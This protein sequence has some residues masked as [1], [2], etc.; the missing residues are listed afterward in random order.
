MQLCRKD[1]P[2]YTLIPALQKKSM[3]TDALDKGRSGQPRTSKV[4][5]D[6][7]LNQI[8]PD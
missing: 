8:I 2:P 7:F 1:I 5:V 3:V 6:R 4:N